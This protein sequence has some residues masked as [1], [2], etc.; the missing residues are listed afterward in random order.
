MKKLLFT[1]VTMMLYSSISAQGFMGGGMPPMGGGM[2]EM[3]PE[4]IAKH[5]ANRLK[6]KCKLDDKQYEAVYELY[7]N[8]AKEMQEDFKNMN[9]DEPSATFKEMDAKM[10]ERTENM[11]NAMKE[12][13]TEEQYKKYEKIAK[14]GFRPQ[15]NFGGGMPPM[16]G[17]FG[18]GMPPMGGGFGGF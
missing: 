12:I 2:P 7:L 1:I 5:Q 16:G 4:T 6:K 18:G 17:G 3:N 15:P 11:N 10:K 13:L 8:Q 9:F 14:R